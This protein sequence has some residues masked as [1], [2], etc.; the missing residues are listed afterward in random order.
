ML[1][2]CENIPLSPLLWSL[3]IRKLE[4]CWEAFPHMQTGNHYTPD[5]LALLLPRT[6]K[7]SSNVLNGNY[8]LQH[9][10]WS[11]C[12][13]CTKNLTWRDCLFH[14]PAYLRAGQLLARMTSLALPCRIIFRVC[15]YPSTYL[16]LFI[17]SWSLE[18]IDSRDFFCK[19]CR[20]ALF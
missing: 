6:I 1:L 3:Q 16:P 13:I 18:F 20:K 12:C 7:H 19:R 9:L 11:T 5:N 10:T 15:L 2:Q 14:T 8:S 17:T 4:K